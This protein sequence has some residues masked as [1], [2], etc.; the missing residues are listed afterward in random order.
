MQNVA[1]EELSAK[2]GRSR[3]APAKRTVK[4]AH[5][6]DCGKQTRKELRDFGRSLREV[7]PRRSHGDWEAEADRPDPLEILRRQERG[8][9]KEL[10]PVRYGRMLVSPFTFYR[11]SA[12]VMASKPP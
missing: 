1:T 4:L 3:T 10:I 9:V 7:A 6:F 12:A 2:A 11:G 5:L 8:R